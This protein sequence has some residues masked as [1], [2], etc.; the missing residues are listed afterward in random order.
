MAQIKPMNTDHND[1]NNLSN[2]NS[3]SKLKKRSTLSEIRSLRLPNPNSD[4]SHLDRIRQRSVLFDQQLECWFSLDADLMEVASQNEVF[5]LHGRMSV[6]WQDNISHNFTNLFDAKK[7]EFFK[8]KGC[9]QYKD[10]DVDI[11]KRLPFYNEAFIVNAVDMKIKTSH[12]GLWDHESSDEFAWEFYIDFIASINERF[13]LD[14]FPFD[15]QFLNVHIAYKTSDYFFTSK[16]PQFILDDPSRKYKI[17]DTHKAI[18]LSM[19][20]S[21]QDSWIMF[22]PW[23]DFGHNPQSS[24][25]LIRLRVR[26]EPHFVLINRILPLFLVVSCGFAGLSMSMDEYL[27]NKI[28]YIQFI[29]TLLLTLSAF[30]YTLSLSLPQTPQITRIDAYILYGYFILYASV[31]EISL[32]SLISDDGLAAAVHYIVQ[33]VMIIIWF[34]KSAQFGYWYWKLSNNAIDWQRL[35]DEEMNH[36]DTTKMTVEKGKH[37]GSNDLRDTHSMFFL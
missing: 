4:D 13:E 3:I 19:K 11:R 23:I 20:D 17:F 35:S 21:L 12:L 37:R 30:Q 6:I 27:E 15:A 24:R 33:Y 18:K 16:C 26:R 9:I 1:A 36:L 10:M 31:V 28:E 5:V 2:G 7:L 22:P 34:Y 29:V 8:N 32:T 25:G 14:E